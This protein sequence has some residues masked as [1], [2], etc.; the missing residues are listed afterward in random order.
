MRIDPPVSVP[1]RDDMPD[2][3]AAAEPP[4]VRRR[5]R[6][7]ERLRTGPKPESSLVVPNA[8]SCRLVLP[9]NTRRPLCSRRVTTASRGHVRLA[10]ERSGG[11][12]HAFWSIRSLS[13]INA[14]QRTDPP[15]RRDFLSADC[16]APA[17]HPSSP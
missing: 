17:L 4:L 6:W 9:T 10:H 15:A 8:N 1:T 2:A 5:A 13:E 7:I 14:V 3:T 12:A 16:A 11:G